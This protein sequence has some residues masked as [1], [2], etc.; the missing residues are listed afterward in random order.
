[1]TSTASSIFGFV[2]S[3]VCTRKA[4]LR[5]RSSDTTRSREEIL[6]ES[7][8]LLGILWAFSRA[9]CLSQNF[10]CTIASSLQ[11]LGRHIGALEDASFTRALRH[12]RQP[13]WPHSL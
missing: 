12:K 11:S 5:L 7:T 2:E 4:Y 10:R 13:L 1:M 6:Y 3:E 9:S 8:N